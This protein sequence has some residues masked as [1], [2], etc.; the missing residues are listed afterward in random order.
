MALPV[1]ARRI[2]KEQR[3]AVDGAK[4]SCPDP[5]ACYESGKTRTTGIRRT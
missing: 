4:R 2:L 1:N 5:A 3:G